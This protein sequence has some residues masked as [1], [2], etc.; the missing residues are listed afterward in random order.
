M[1]TLPL[2]IVACAL[3]GLG[4]VAHAECDKDADAAARKPTSFHYEMIGGRRV[5]VIDPQM[6]ICGHPARP[7][8]AVVTTAK[9]VEYQWLTL[10]E[11]FLPRILESVKKAPLGGQR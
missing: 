9:D 2:S 11:Q 5:T 8:V 10:E 3:L 1:Q 6:I 4:T 7:A